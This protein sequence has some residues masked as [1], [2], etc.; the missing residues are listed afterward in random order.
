MATEHPG[1]QFGRAVLD[2]VGPVGEV[3]HAHGGDDGRGH[4]QHLARR[5]GEGQGLRDVAQHI[6]AG[7]DRR[8]EYS[9]KTG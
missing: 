9:S 8:K 1:T 4:R 5:E 6:H 3:E 2:V 7:T